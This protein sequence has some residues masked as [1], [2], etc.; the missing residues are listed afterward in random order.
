VPELGQA[1]L[2]Q[3]RVVDSPVAGFSAGAAAA[4]LRKDGRIDLALIAGEAA[5]PAAAV[6]TQNRLA[7]APVQ[8]ARRHVAGGRIRAV[9]ANSGGAN[10]ATGAKGLEA[11]LTTCQAAAQ[12]L[13]C[14]AEE[15]FPCSTGVIG[16]L[17]PADKITA[18]LPQ[19]AADLSPQGL[20]QAAGAIMTTDAFKKMATASAVIQNQPVT[21]VGFAKGAGMIHPD[22][23]TMLAFVLTDAAASTP[24]L[25]K[26]LNIAV[27]LSFNR[28]SV[29]GDT[30]TNDTLL[31]LASGKAGNRELQADDPELAV[32]TA[33]VTKVCQELAAMLVADGEGAGHLIRVVITGAESDEAA[34]HTAFAIAHSPLC[35]TAFAGRD[36]NWGRLL[37]TAG[38]EAA[39]RGHSF[40][41]E[42]CRLW[43]GDALIAENGVYTSAQAEEEAARVMKRERYQVRLDLGLGQ[44]K[45]WVFTS[46]LDHKYIE[47]NADYRS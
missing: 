39:R 45:F 29:D 16:Q 24:A 44:G 20:P 37:S 10:A 33:A 26:A 31:L 13:H 1:P 23:A 22:M 35:K 32:L 12:A 43:I 21:V 6:F 25:Q 5:Y 42:K 8:V 27:E 18:A 7:A 38:A 9:L 36:P 4:G 47:I 30:S 11:C 46:D 28:A 34:R 41:E 2:K 3:D 19:L 14:R 40:A 15:V 17:L